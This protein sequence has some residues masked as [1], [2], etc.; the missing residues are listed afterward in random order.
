MMFLDTPFHRACDNLGLDTL[1][2][3][4]EGEETELGNKNN[5]DLHDKQWNSMLSM[6]INQRI[7]NE[8][9]PLVKYSQSHYHLEHDPQ[10]VH[11]YSCKFYS[12]ESGV[13]LGDCDAYVVDAM[14]MMRNRFHFHS[15]MDAYGITEA[16]Y[17][18]IYSEHHD[19]PDYDDYFEVSVFNR[20]VVEILQ[21][22]TLDTNMLL[23]N[24]PVWRKGF[25]DAKLQLSLTE[26]LIRRLSI[27]CG[28]TAVGIYNPSDYSEYSDTLKN[29][30][31]SPS[32]ERKI[33]KEVAFYG[34]LGF[35]SLPNSWL[36]I[37]PG[38]HCQDVAKFECPIINPTPSPPPPFSSEDNIEDEVFGDADSFENDACPDILDTLVDDY[39]SPHVD[40]LAAQW[41]MSAKD[42]KKVIRKTVAKSI[43]HDDIEVSWDVVDSVVN[44]SEE[45]QYS[46]NHLEC[47]F[48]GYEYGI[49][50]ATL[51]CALIDS[52]SLYKNRFNRSGGPESIRPIQECLQCL[53]LK[54]GDI[55]Y[56]DEIT[57]LTD[58]RGGGNILLLKNFILKPYVTS[59]VTFEA[60]LGSLL[61]VIGSGCTIIVA[62]LNSTDIAICENESEGN[63]VPIRSTTTNNPIAELYRKVGF[64]PI[65]GNNYM[66]M[67]GETSLEY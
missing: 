54:D 32:Y 12:R 2:R 59:E 11:N 43:E 50:Y 4:L 40:R 62:M 39:T 24:G 25:Y 15:G 67:P 49:H 1:C 29:Y 27:G 66:V 8:G 52:H 18:P 55:F 56:T 13:R 7:I 57:N 14:A 31:G 45:L 46:I 51:S 5:W 17:S 21:L 9:P 53:Y 41:N 22:D 10:Y 38:D 61:K 26:R 47:E 65:A 35:V 44:S 48:V 28:V 23:I 60:E 20:N 63:I 42:W 3:A 37:R 34:K 6:S 16:C 19:F 58:G 33:I 30:K 64:T 36:Y